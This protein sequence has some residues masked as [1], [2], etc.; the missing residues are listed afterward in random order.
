MYDEYRRILSSLDPAL[1]AC[2]GCP[3]ECRQI[4]AE[5]TECR[6]KVCEWKASETRSNV[7][8]PTISS[9]CLVRECEELEEMCAWC[10]PSL[11]SCWS[12]RVGKE[13]E[14]DQESGLCTLLSRCGVRPPPQPPLI[15]HD[16]ASWMGKTVGSS[17]RSC[18]PGDSCCWAGYWVTMGR[19][20]SPAPSVTLY[21][22]RTQWWALLSNHCGKLGLV[23]E[24][25][26]EL[27]L[28][29]LVDLDINCL[30][31]LYSFPVT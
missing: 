31:N 29:Q 13:L 5:G 27:L 2:A 9:L 11:T 10:K 3:T 19:V 20:T 24:T 18:I 25:D 7:W 1:Y 26:W 22:W 15:A 4:P 6:F 23:Q 30:R 28:H 8:Y 21:H 17:L 12:W 16:Q 14:G